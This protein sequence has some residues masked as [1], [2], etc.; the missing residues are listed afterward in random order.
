MEA[1]GVLQRPTTRLAC[2]LLIVCVTTACGDMTPGGGGGNP[3]TPTAPTAAEAGFSA[4]SVH[5]P[6]IMNRA[7][8]STSRFG[9]SRGGVTKKALD[10]NQA[11]DLVGEALVNLVDAVVQALMDC[12]I[13]S[14][15]QIL[16]PVNTADSC[17]VGGR[18]ARGAAHPAGWTRRGVCRQRR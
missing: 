16:C 3:L 14:S 1:R 10:P 5:L 12:P 15:G 17:D 9:S 6:R 7:G 11:A 18:V 2:L 8:R 13:E 4:R